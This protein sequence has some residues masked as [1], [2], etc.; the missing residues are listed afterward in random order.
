[1]FED[2]QAALSSFAANT[3]S[4][5]ED[6]AHKQLD[7]VSLAMTGNNQP[8]LD[9]V[10]LTMTGVNLVQESKEIF[11]IGNEGLAENYAANQSQGD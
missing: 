10:A 8:D 4:Y 9:Y 5:S 7:F 1:L 11:V 2:V 6:S 3:A